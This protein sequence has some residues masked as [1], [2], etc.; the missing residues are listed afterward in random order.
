MKCRDYW[1]RLLMNFASSSKLLKLKLRPASASLMKIRPF[2]VQICFHFKRF[3]SLLISPKSFL[4]VDVND[5]D[6]YTLLFTTVFVDTR[7]WKTKH[8]R[9]R[10]QNFRRSYV[11]STC[12][13]EIYQSQPLMWPSTTCQ[14][15]VIGGFRSDM[16]IT[17]M[18]DGNFGNVSASVL[19]S[20]VEY[21]RKRW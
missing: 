9:K 11:L 15:A 12:R 6:K 5:P 2:W 3:L 7:L 14:R 21:Q 13:I 19:F 4:R 16:S 17:R 18:I 1:Q 10:F 8:S 20:K